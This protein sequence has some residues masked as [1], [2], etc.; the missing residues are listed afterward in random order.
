MLVTYFILPAFT[1]FIYFTPFILI[2]YLFI[3]FSK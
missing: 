2:K 3:P 1:L